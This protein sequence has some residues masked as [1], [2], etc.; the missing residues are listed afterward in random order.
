MAHHCHGK[1]IS[2]TTKRK[3]QG[4]K[5]TSRQKEKPH[6]KKKR[7]HAKISLM[8]R[9]HVLFLFLLPWGYSFCHEVILF[10]ERFFFLPWGF[11]VCPE[12]N[13]FPT[14]V[15]WATVPLKFSSRRFLIFFNMWVFV[16]TST[17]FA[18]LVS[19]HYS[20]IEF[21]DWPVPKTL[22]IFLCQTSENKAFKMHCSS[23]VR[24][25]KREHDLISSPVSMLSARSAEHY[26]HHNNMRRNE[27]SSSKNPPGNY[28]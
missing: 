4:K 9:G 25:E 14:T 16:R 26:D 11:C 7:T 1:R 22:D 28:A 21:V 20:S 8:P 27:S 13:S 3:P 15:G 5:K 23:V 10:A 17:N 18:H 12:V 6:G 24:G 2:L 19:F